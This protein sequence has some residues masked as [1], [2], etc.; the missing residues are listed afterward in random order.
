MLKVFGIGFLTSIGG[1]ILG[2]LLGWVFVFAAGPLGPRTDEKLVVTIF[3]SVA[4]GS[5]SIVG[6]IAGAVWALEGKS[7]TA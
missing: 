7:E 4:W 1:L 3:S 5:G 2:V 6:A